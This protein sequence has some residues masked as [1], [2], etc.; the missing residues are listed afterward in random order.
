MS[1]EPREGFFSGLGQTMSET[2]DRGRG[3]GEIPVS[4]ETFLQKYQDLLFTT[5]FHPF[6]PLETEHPFGW[7][8]RRALLSLYKTG[9]LN[10][11]C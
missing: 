11:P 9:R 10:F 7:L 1:K 6:L 8:G 4:W 2:G 3:W 5:S